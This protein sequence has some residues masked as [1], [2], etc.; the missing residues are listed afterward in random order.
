MNAVV[1]ELLNSPELLEVVAELN[2]AVE[3][4]KRRRLQFYA[5]ITPNMKAE[6]INGQPVYHSPARHGHN[7]ASTAIIRRLIPFVEEANAGFVAVEKAM[8][9]LPRNDFEP[10]ICYFSSE[11]AKSFT[12]EMLHYPAPDFV[13]EI[14]SESTQ[15]NDRGVKFRDYEAHGVAEY[16]IVDPVA[17]TIE[18][19]VLRGGK[20]ALEAK[21]HEGVI[22]SVA[23]PGWRF[24]CREA[25]A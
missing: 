8:V 23:V 11:K 3:E 13:V 5:D 7:K 1:E 16:W 17:E 19:Y 12:R 15:A 18:Q 24:S 21:V 14:L 9:S 4:E 22:E 20:Y 25:F 2:A 6:F 10:D